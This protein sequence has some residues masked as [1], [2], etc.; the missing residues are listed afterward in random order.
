MF[1]WYVNK[2]TEQNLPLQIHTGYLAGNWKKLENGRPFKLD[3]L[4]LKY[5][6]T[7]FILFHG[8]YPWYS[9]VGALAK[10]F[11]NVYLDIVWLPQISREAAVDA[12]REISQ[13]EF[14][15]PGVFRI[16]DPEETDVGLKLY[17]VEGTTLD[18]IVR[19]RGFKP[20]ERCLFIGSDLL[21][22]EGAMAISLV[23]GRLEIDGARSRNRSRPWTRDPGTRFRR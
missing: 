6:D 13:G 8:G 2:C 4:F 19:L 21:R 1:H 7:K 11:P 17:G 14:G 18:K 12:S 23:E 10:N 5:R 22:R 9:E 15:M 20:M 16:S 3:N